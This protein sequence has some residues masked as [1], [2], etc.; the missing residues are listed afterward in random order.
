MKIV[1]NIILLSICLIIS[2]NLLI[3]TTTINELMTNKLTIFNKDN[4]IIKNCKITII[5]ITDDT[6]NIIK[7]F[8]S[9]DPNEVMRLINTQNLYLQ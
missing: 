3:K 2:S 5:T 8:D 4:N 1:N 9:S 7:I 6:G